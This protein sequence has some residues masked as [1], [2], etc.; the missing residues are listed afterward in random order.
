MPATFQKRHY[1][2]VAQL[3]QDQF[4]EKGRKQSREEYREQIISAFVIAFRRDNP[5]F[6]GDR[7]RAACAPGANVRSRGNVGPAMPYYKGAR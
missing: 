4:P 3:L 5:N 6:S 2:A 7:F 1:E